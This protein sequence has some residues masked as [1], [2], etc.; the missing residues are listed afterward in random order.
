MLPLKQNE[1][2]CNGILATKSVTGSIV[3]ARPWTVVVWHNDGSTCTLQCTLS[4]TSHTFVGFPQYI[5]QSGS[6]TLTSYSP[7]C[8]NL[9]TNLLGCDKVVTT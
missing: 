5:L 3:Y 6:K 4:V 2:Y 1:K 7:C 9:V 8:N